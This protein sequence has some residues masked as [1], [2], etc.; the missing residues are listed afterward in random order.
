MAITTFKMH[1]VKNDVNIH[2]STSP[3]PYL[4]DMGCYNFVM[5]HPND[6]ILSA[7]SSPE[8][9]FLEGHP[10]WYYYRISTLN[11]GVRIGS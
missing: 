1:C 4:Y 3:F 11:C 5:T 8:V 10:S 2:I 6:T 9:D 7:F